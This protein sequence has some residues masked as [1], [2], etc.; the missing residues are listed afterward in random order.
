MPILEMGDI[1][2]F[3]IGAQKI[4]SDDDDQAIHIEGHQNQPASFDCFVENFSPWL[5]LLL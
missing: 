4:F 3:M 1:Q 5:S 2:A